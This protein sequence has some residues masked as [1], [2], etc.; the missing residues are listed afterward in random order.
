MQGA[1]MTIDYIEAAAM[2]P[3][4]NLKTKR[5]HGE[6]RSHPRVKENDS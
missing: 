2:P 1:L 4:P 3:T 6:L 5:R